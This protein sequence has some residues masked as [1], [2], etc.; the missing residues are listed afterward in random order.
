MFGELIQ[1]EGSSDREFVLCEEKGVVFG[2]V[3]K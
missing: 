3:Y 1:F 2:R